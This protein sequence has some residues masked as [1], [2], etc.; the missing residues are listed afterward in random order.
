MSGRPSAIGFGF[1]PFG[2]YPFGSADWAEEVTWKFLPLHNRDDDYKAPFDPAFPL[3]KYINAIKPTIQEIKDKYEQ[4]PDLWDA[5][6]VPIELLDQLGYNFDTFPNQNKDERLR[7]SE[8]LNAI[9]FFLNKGLDKGYD[10]AAAFSG[11]LASVTPYWA[12]TCAP[13]S[14]ITTNGP[15]EFYPTLDNFP[16]DTVAADL[17]YDD[18]FARWPKQ[19]SWEDPCRTA[20]L[21]LFLT[22]ADDTEIE[23]FSV[24]ADDAISNIERVRPIHVRISNIRFDGPRAIGGSWSIPVIAES[25]AVGGSWTIPVVA[26]LRASS[27]TWTIPVTAIP[28]P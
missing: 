17:V 5:N 19:L 10:I 22:T 4:F 24:I 12:E 21:D 15:T 20:F 13:A 1:Q 27:A 7:R 25:Y 23:N 8:V 28:T 14:P 11:L 16:A 2:D 26:E 6:R 3:R 9:Q 18:F